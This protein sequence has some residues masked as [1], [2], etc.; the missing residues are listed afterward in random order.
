MVLACSAAL[1]AAGVSQGVLIGSR[2]F[3]STDSATFDQLAAHLFLGGHNP[4]ATPLRGAST[5]LHPTANYWTYLANGGHVNQVSY[6]AGSFLFLV[7]FIIVGVR[8]LTTDWV[9]LFAWLWTG[10]LLYFMVPRF[11]RWIAPLLVLSSVFLVPFSNGGTDALFVPF[12]VV[13]C[14]RWDRYG[15]GIQAG[16]ASWIGPVALGIACSIKQGPWFCVPFLVLGVALEAK[17]AGRSPIATASRYAFVVALVFLAINAPFIVWNAR[18]WWHGTTLPFAQ[19]LVASGFGVVT[20]AVHGLTGGAVLSKL[21][22]GGLFLL[23]SLLLA[24]AFWYNEW[25]RAWLFFLPI[26]LMLPSRSLTNYLLDFFPAGLVSVITLRAVPRRVHR[27]LSGAFCSL[28]VA[29]PLIVAVTLVT[30]G[31]TSAPLEVESISATAINDV[32]SG[33]QYFRTIHVTVRNNSDD[34]LSPHFLVDQG[35]TGLAGFWS[36]R[37]VRGSLPVLAHASTTLIL[38]PPSSIETPLP[39]DYWVLEIYTANPTALSTSSPQ[40]WK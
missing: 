2:Q 10:F 6:P 37:V 20:L 17:A 7:P 29:I 16:A 30:E 31:L 9:D 8:H 13:A 39:G 1:V 22:L 15:E 3:Y 27:K 36:A 21:T 14:W 33:N 5:L 34:S 26:V 35:K 12:L 4:Y 28:L 24:Y 23:V 11:M 40:R 25:R 19:P 18:A 38:T 32:H